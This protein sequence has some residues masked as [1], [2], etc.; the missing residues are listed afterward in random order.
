[1]ILQFKKK[2]TKTHHMTLFTFKNYI[3]MTIFSAEAKKDRRNDPCRSAVKI[4][5]HQS[6]GGAVGTSPQTVRVTVVPFSNSRPA[7]SD[8]VQTVPGTLV[9]L[10]FLITF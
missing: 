1:M 9:P 4:S 2:S 7:T 8:I 5:V 6:V 3:F 10:F